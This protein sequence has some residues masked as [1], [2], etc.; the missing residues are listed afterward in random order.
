[1]QK[2][3]LPVAAFFLGFFGIFGYLYIHAQTSVPVRVIPKTTTAPTPEPTFALVPPASSVTGV[4]AVTR[5]HAE[6]FSRG[7]TEYKEAST[8]AQILPGESVATKAESGAVVTVQTIVTSALSEQAE[9]V[10]ANMFLNNFVVQQK[11]G[12]ISYAASKPISVRVLHSLVSIQPGE[13]LIT[14]TDSDVDISVKTGSAKLALV[15]L[16]NDTHVWTLTEGDSA[17]VSDTS[18]RVR[19]VHGR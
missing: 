19:L 18:R 3:L 4:L 5:G 7:D 8:G 9:L 10:Y 14:I 13:T 15:D 12:E 6:K 11:A 2:I 16:N 17:S 1:M